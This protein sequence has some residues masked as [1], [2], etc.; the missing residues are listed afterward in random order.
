[1]LT[2]EAGDRRVYQ[3]CI[4]IGLEAAMGWKATGDPTVRRQRDKWVVRVDGIDTETGRHKPRQLGTFRSKRAAATAARR[5]SSEDLASER[6]TLGWLVKRYVASR[7]DVSVKA[8][9]QYAWAASHIATGLGAVPLDRLERE[10]IARWLEEMASAGKLSRRS[11]QIC[12]NVLRA[13]LADAVDEGLLRRSPAARVAMPR[14]VAKPERER[15]VQ[16]WSALEV[17]DFLTTTSEHAWAAGFRLAVLYGL[18]RSELLAL[19]WDDFSAKEGSIRV[20]E[21]LVA[22]DTGEAWTNAKNTRSRRVIPL[23]EQTVKVLTAR[24][25]RQVEERLLAGAGWVDHDL[26]LTT[27]SGNPVKPRSFDR[28]LDVLVK[29]SG[30]PRLSSHGLRHTA[31]THMVSGAADL[32]EL[33][34]VADILGHSP[35]MLL[36]VYA[37][38]L[39]ASVRAVADRIGQRG[40]TLSTPS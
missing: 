6:G 23:D 21:G 35:E 39:P 27:R 9:E 1:M 34:A 37:H 24:K 15:E 33:R 10:D 30:V 14:H 3:R 20:D 18:R 29:R 13:A 17:N 36:R 19:R 28:T 22:T 2:H 4:R 26:I 8:R 40:A 25:R 11:I 38:A 7:T 32:G 31:A 16:A 5:A 12:R